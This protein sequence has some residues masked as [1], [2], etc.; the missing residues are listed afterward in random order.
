[1]SSWMNLFTAGGFE[2]VWATSMKYSEGMSRRFSTGV[3]Y[4]A[5]IISFYF[6]S[7]AVESIPVGTACAVWAGIGAIGTAIQRIGSL[8]ATAKY[9]SCA[10][11][12]RWSAY[13]LA[14]SAYLLAE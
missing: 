8:A 2:I 12:N 4:G 6:L 1:M 13:L 11:R 14:W 3:M 9:R 10:R 7:V 5:G